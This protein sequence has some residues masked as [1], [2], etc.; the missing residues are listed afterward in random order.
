MASGPGRYRRRLFDR[1]RVKL[2]SDHSLADCRADDL[3]AGQGFLNIEAM[4]LQAAKKEGEQPSVANMP[5]DGQIV[6]RVRSDANTG[7]KFNEF[8]GR[9]SYIKGMS[10]PG[11]KVLRLVNPKDGTVLL[12]KPF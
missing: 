3:P 6:T 2:P 12:G 9:E 4:L 10:Q 8:F 5:D 11:R 7:A 1:L